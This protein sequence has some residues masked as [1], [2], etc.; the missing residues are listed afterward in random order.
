MSDVPE[1]N[2]FFRFVVT[3]FPPIRKNRFRVTI[4]PFLGDA[5]AGRSRN[6]AAPR[7]DARNARGEQLPFAVVAMGYLNSSASERMPNRECSTNTGTK[8]GFDP[9][10]GLSLVMAFLLCTLLLAAFG[11]FTTTPLAHRLEEQMGGFPGPCR[12]VRRSAVAIVAARYSAELQKLF[13]YSSYDV[14]T[15]EQTRDLRLRA[16]ASDRLVVENLGERPAE[17]VLADE[18]LRS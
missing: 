12:V 13:T 18:V 16:A 15:I 1:M 6:L 2:S 11:L 8:G 7:S 3:V 4:N 5:A 9:H 17:R 14:R 10:L